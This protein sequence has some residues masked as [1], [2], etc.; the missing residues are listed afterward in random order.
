MPNRTFYCRS[1]LEV[2][3]PE[4]PERSTPAKDYITQAYYGGRCE[5][6][7][8]SLRDGYHYDINSM[9]ASAFCMPMPT[10]VPHYLQYS[11]DGVNNLFP[12]E[13]LVEELSD[14]IGFF[15]VR[16]TLP[17]EVVQNNP[18]L[19][20]HPLLPL[21]T[22]E[23]IVSPF[24][25]WYGTY[26]ST[27]LKMAHNLGYIIEVESGYTFSVDNSMFHNFISKFYAMRQY[28]KQTRNKAV[29]QVAKLIM[30]SAYGRFALGTDPTVV[31][32]T[33]DEDELVQ[34]YQWF[35]VV[36]VHK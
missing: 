28:A 3:N 33:V 22:E 18:L 1:S 31:E 16:V 34:I 8:P 32:M 15:R 2:A 12:F 13:Q 29:D 5:A 4:H 21:R 20:A 25:T 19:T 11:T 27:E 10:G 23:R 14:R 36:E 17:P 24:G 26:P 35:N 7:Y 9:Y 30:N 6:A